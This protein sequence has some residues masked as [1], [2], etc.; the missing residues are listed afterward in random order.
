MKIYSAY[1]RMGPRSRLIAQINKRVRP[2]LDKEVD[3]KYFLAV[4]ILFAV[5]FSSTSVI[6]PNCVA[7]CMAQGLP[8]NY[9][10]AICSR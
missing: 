7:S 5:I 4:V 8:A 3:M 9:C 6:D 1:L 2:R 10:N